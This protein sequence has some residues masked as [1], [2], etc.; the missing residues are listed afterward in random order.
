MTARAI[1]VGC[2]LALSTV[3]V[4]KALLDTVSPMVVW[5]SDHINGGF[6][7]IAPR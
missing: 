6:H 2:V 3:A 4:A 5:L 1:A 7:A